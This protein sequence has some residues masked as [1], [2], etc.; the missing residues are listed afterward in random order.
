MRLH[1]ATGFISLTFSEEDTSLPLKQLISVNRLSFPNTLISQLG[2]PPNGVLLVLV[3]Y[4]MLL[5]TQPLGTTSYSHMSPRSILQVLLTHCQNIQISVL[6]SSLM[7]AQT[8]A[9]NECC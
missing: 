6:Q 9:G 8:E 5:E 7:G 1:T 2:V 4:K 3:K